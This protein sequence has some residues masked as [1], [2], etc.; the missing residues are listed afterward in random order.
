MA[1]V[2]SVLSVACYLLFV[3]FWLKKHFVRT[4]PT[5]RTNN[6]GSCCFREECV[7]LEFFL[8]DKL[9]ESKGSRDPKFEPA[10]QERKKTQQK[11]S[12]LSDNIICLVASV[13]GG[14]Q[15]VAFEYEWYDWR[16]DMHVY[17]SCQQQL[18]EAGYFIFS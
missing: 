9:D 15:H 17:F 14:W 3:G 13:C 10:N 6:N 16:W 5:H 18:I 4:R 1:F 12:L 7:G 8:I 2:F 11:N